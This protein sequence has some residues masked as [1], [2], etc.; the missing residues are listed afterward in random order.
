MTCIR[1]CLILRKVLLQ[2]TTPEQFI[3]GAKMKLKTMLMQHFGVTKKEHY[4]M[5]WYFLAWSI[6][7]CLLAILCCVFTSLFRSGAGKCWLVSIP[8]Q[9]CAVGKM[10]G[11]QCCEL[12]KSSVPSIEFV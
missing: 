5:L 8:L 12:V 7:C 9:G 3:L 4:D 10:E 2:L 11:A 1:S 6:A